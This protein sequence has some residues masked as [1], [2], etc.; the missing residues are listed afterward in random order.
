MHSEG[1]SSAVL[2]ITQ[3]SPTYLTLSTTCFPPHSS[4]LSSTKPLL[5][6]SLS[7]LLFL[8]IPLQSFR[9][10]AVSPFRISIQSGFQVLHAQRGLG[11]EQSAGRRDT[12]PS[13]LVS[14]VGA[15]IHSSVFA[16][17]HEGAFLLSE[18]DVFDYVFHI[19]FKNLLCTFLSQWLD[20]RCTFL[21]LTKSSS[22]KYLARYIVMPLLIDRKKPVLNDFNPTR[23]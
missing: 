23:E 15:L 1:P 17:L 8:Q 4:S 10:Q 14:G 7:S 5:R 20:T 18:C 22:R 12:I 3:S 11:D 2:Y 21:V 19:A 13:N 9:A 6:Y 16:C